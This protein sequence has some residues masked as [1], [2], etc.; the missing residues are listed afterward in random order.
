MNTQG[1]L[2]VGVD[3]RP[4]AL[5]AVAWAARE[6]DRRELSVRLVAVVPADAPDPAAAWRRAGE[7]LATARRVALATAAV[8]TS[9]ESASG[10]PASVLAR[11]CRPATLLVL[12]SDGEAGEPVPGGLPSAVVDGAAC[13]V[14]VVPARWDADRHAG[15]VVVAVDPTGPEEIRRATVTLA[16]DVARHWSRPLLVAVVLPGAHTAPRV[17]AACRAFDA[18]TAEAGQDVT[19]HQVLG[20]G[21]PAEELRGL[22]GPSTGLV[23]LGATTRPHDAADAV[24]RAVRHR[25]RCPV[26]VVPVPVVSRPGAAASLTASGT[27]V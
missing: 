5:R 15:E 27:S 21:D 16:A 23:V 13:P 10:D 26:A 12:G 8:A 25:A 14:V 20:H 1:P 7:D 9:T 17:G 22:V 18:C 11:G 24:G 6:A 3:G 2:V 4:A 19:V